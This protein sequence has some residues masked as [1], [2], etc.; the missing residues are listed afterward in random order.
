[1]KNVI[2]PEMTI[3]GRAYGILGFLRGDETSVKGNVMVARAKELGAN[4]GKGDGEFILASQAEIPEALRGKV[5]LVFTDWRDSS[6]SEFVAYAYWR[7]GRWIHRW[8][9]L[10]YGWHDDVRLLRRK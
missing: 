4:L 10:G 9:W 5:V 2:L 3:G 7:R 6:D 1:M 8:R